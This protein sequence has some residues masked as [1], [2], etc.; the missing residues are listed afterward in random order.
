VEASD[1][2]V[3]QRLRPVAR[4]PAER[5]VALV[6]PRGAEALVAG[7]DATY[8]FARVDVLSRREHP[9][10]PARTPAWSQNGT[11]FVTA[12]GLLAPPDVR[13]QMLRHE[14]IHSLHQRAAPREES[15]AARADAE[16]LAC[17]PAAFASVHA[18]PPVPAL[19]AFPPQPHKPFDQVWIGHD[20]IVGEIVASGITVRV[21]LPYAAIGIDPLGGR[22][23]RE[24][25]CGKHDR[26]PIP[27]IV[28]KMVD[29][30]QI[31]AKLNKDLPAGAKP[32][33]AR[34]V[35]VAPDAASAYRVA[36]GKPVIIMKMAEL[37]GGQ[38][39]DTL[40]HETSHALY[41]FHSVAADA[42]KRTADPYALRV[43]DLFVRAQATKDV[44]RPTT[45]FDAARPPPLEYDPATSVTTPAPAAVVMV[46]DTLWAG[47]GGHPWDGP[48]E[49][50]ASA[51]A[52]FLKARELQ[53]QIFAHYGK[54]EPAIARI[55]KELL[56]L[57]G[58]ATEA[59]KLAKLK[60]P[61]PPAEAARAIERAGAPTDISRDVTVVGWAIDPTTMPGPDDITCS[62]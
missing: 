32:F 33:T 35:G 39:P 29:A 37:V 20:A 8:D 14:A 61:K 1:V 31:T 15:A 62:P 51:Y 34:L 45:K 6:R 22:P 30:A 23:G 59:G 36:N 27:D 13:S 57:L 41:E 47:E 38:Y 24:F 44:P 28:K 56:E 7:G 25:H 60:P 4:G 53:K 58:M 11:V 5:Q 43:A 12:E 18:F 2:R 48:D 54:A 52:G 3:Q 46:T 50:F 26:P 9:A 40:A 42:K 19:L 49:F 55:A 21:A 10:L 17:D 16:R